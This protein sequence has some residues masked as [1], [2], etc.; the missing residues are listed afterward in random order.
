MPIEWW[1][2]GSTA[3][4]SPPPHES[5]RMAGISHFVPQVEVVEVVEVEIRKREIANAFA[6]GKSLMKKHASTAPPLHHTYQRMDLGSRIER[7]WAARS[8]RQ[9][10]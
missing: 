8:A 5:Q 9:L 6:S 4:T 1:S 10:R 7:R 3:S 2:E